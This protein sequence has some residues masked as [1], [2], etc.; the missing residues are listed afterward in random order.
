[1]PYDKIFVRPDPFFSMQKMVTINGAVRFPGEYAILRSDETI[2]D[3]IQRAGGLR[4]NAFKIGSSFSRGGKR[5]NI[6]M[7]KVINRKKSSQNLRVYEGDVINIALKPDIIQILGEVNSPGFYQYN[8]SFR[9][10]NI[11]KNAGGLTQQG[12]LN[13]IF[14][15]Y[16]NGKSIKYTKWLRNP[17][18]LDGSIVTVGAKP[19]KVPFDLT[20]Y[21]T[22]MT[23][24]T[25][26]L[27]QTISIVLIAS[28]R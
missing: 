8:K 22:E 25:A 4:P 15:T 26:N 6:D 12:D 14:I 17:K 5:I 24:I 13:N 20:Q 21:L 7:K 27:A 11:I 9:V 2:Y 1:M 16:A 3:I 19:E 10:S 18:V 28:R 23:A